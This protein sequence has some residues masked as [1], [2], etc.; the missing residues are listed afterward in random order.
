MFLPVSS[1]FSS[2]DRIHLFAKVGEPTHLPGEVMAV[3][4]WLFLCGV[5]TKTKSTN[6]G[7]MLMLIDMIDRY[8]H[9]YI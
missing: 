1:C 5:D 6:L 8:I 4:G 9:I 2:G 7:H 3:L